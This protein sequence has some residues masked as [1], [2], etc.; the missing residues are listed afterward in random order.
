MF[1]A[2]SNRLII[3]VGVVLAIVAF[4]GITAFLGSQQSTA[5]PQATTR[6]VLVANEDIEVGEEVTPAKVEVRQVAPDAVSGTPLADPSMLGQRAALFSVAQGQQVNQETFGNTTNGRLDIAGQL[7]PGERA[8]AFQ[9]DRVTGLDFMLQQGDVIDVVVSVDVAADGDRGTRTVKAVLQGKR[10]L[11]VSSAELLS[12]PGG[13]N[14]AEGEDDTEQAPLPPADQAIVIFAGTDQDAE[15]IKFAQR[16]MGE[17]GSITVALRG[18]GDDQTQRTT[19]VTLAQLIQDYG[20]VTP[21]RV[22]V[23]DAVPAP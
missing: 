10:V 12:V 13:T 20:V 21:S 14:E 9:V 8:V 2:R 7:R 6:N 3:V 23:P 19:G 15:V 16:D 5:G 18:R 4:V 11:Y 17:L 1:V 22:T